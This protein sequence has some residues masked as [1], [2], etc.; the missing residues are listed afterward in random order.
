M[1]DEKDEKKS[2]WIGRYGIPSL[3]VSVAAL[4]LQQQQQ[5][6]DRLERVVEAGWQFYS[7]A[8]TQL[9]HSEDADREVS[10]LKVIG[11]AFPNIYCAV[12]QDLYERAWAAQ[13]QNDFK[14]G[15][16]P[17]DQ[18]DLENLRREVQ[19]LS[20]PMRQP[21]PDS[22]VATW[23]AAISPPHTE[24]PAPN[25]VASGTAKPDLT[26]PSGPQIAATSLAPP[27]PPPPAAS[28]APAAPTTEEKTAEAQTTKPG[29]SGV[30]AGASARAIAPNRGL[31]PA[32]AASLS[33][34]AA[35]PAAPIG[36]PPALSPTPTLMRV[37]FHYRADGP[38]TAEFIEP[39]RIELASYNYRVIRG[40]Q[41]M[42][43]EQFPQKSEVRYF[44]E[45][46][47]PAAKQLAAYLSW[48]FSGEGLQFTP[49]A[50]GASYPNLPHE[51][52][53]VWVTNPP[54]A[55]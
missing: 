34:P 20:S 17:I 10:V 4:T 28:S 7:G 52:I 29:S 39:Y 38:R 5:T 12:R 11:N 6:F 30:G 13:P 41:R 55:P 36:P 8:R 53:E 25:S 3:I 43:K 1:A 23:T 51:N 2:G 44:G 40:V 49:R 24:C 42:S 47:A 19:T 9:V 48:K 21:Y 22:I 35:A 27:P 26:T 32:G 50:I 18:A 45:A 54:G 33:V 14:D 37:F 15:H 16:S 31:P 46:E